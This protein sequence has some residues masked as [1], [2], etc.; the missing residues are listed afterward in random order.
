MSSAGSDSYDEESSQGSDD[1]GD[2]ED[3]GSSSSSAE[4][5]LESSA[6]QVGPTTDY[7]FSMDSQHKDFVRSMVQYGDNILI[8]ASEDKTMKIFYF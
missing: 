8:T 3:S 5:E 7:F 2:D 4:D 6:V 1:D